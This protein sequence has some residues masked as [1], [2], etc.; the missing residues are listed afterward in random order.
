MSIPQLFWLLI[1]LGGVTGFIAIASVIFLFGMSIE[2]TAKH[3]MRLLIIGVVTGASAFVIGGR[4]VSTSRQ[5][6]ASPDYKVSDWQVSRSTNGVT[7]I[8]FSTNAPAKV[9]LEYKNRN[10]DSLPLFQTNGTGPS[11]EHIFDLPSPLDAQGEI[12][13]V[14]EGQRIKESLE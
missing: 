13:A 12:W 9:Y 8:E 3:A 4:F 10:G 14:V 6:M 5:S 7:K 2:D 11:V 1:T